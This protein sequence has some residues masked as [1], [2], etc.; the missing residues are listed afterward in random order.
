MKIALVLDDSIDRPDG[1][2]QYV[3]TL[4]AFLARAGHTVH[5]LSSSSSRTD[6]TVHSLARNVG[7]TFNGNGLR[8]PLP[9]SRARIRALLDAERYDVIHVQTPHSPLFAAR[10]VDEAR[11]LQARSVRIVGTFHILPDSKIS[12]WGTHALGRALR[13]NL[14]KFDAFCAVSAPAADFARRTFG[15]DARVIP[16]PVD[17]TGFAAAAAAS[18]RRPGADGRLVIAFLG[19]LVERKG[20]LELIHA[21]DA[22]TEE[23]RQGIEVRIG[24]KGPLFGDLEAAIHAAGI[25]RVAMLGFVAEEDKAAFYADADIAVFPATGGESFGIVLVEA[26]AAGAGVVLAGANPG[27][28]SVIGDRPE[29]SVDARDTPAFADALRRL[30]ADASLR[31]EIHAEQAAHVRQFDVERVGAQV[32]ELYAV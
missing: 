6:V 13:A 31:S 4:G 14:R 18:S 11:R 22:L 23:E 19:R 5:Y 26:M 16:C 15:I 25:D 2:Q 10:V 30:I 21:L 8:I 27:Y 28:L 29:V 12:E 20:V 7:V 3:L 9:T 24:G 32:L 1:V 17:V